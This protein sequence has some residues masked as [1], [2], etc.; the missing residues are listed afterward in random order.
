MRAYIIWKEL[1]SI[2]VNHKVFLGLLLNSYYGNDLSL[3]KSKL[4]RYIADDNKIITVALK[5]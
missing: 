3:Y 4:I 2:C 1:G 5:Y